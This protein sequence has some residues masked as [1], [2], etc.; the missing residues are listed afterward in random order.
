MTIFHTKANSCEQVHTISACIYK[1]CFNFYYSNYT[2]TLI[3]RANSST[4]A[5]GCCLLSWREFVFGKS[6]SSI[7]APVNQAH[8][9]FK[10]GVKIFKNRMIVSYCDASVDDTLNIEISDF[11]LW[12]ASYWLLSGMWEKLFVLLFNNQIWP[13][14]TTVCQSCEALFNLH[15]MSQLCHIFVSFCVIYNLMAV[16]TQLCFF[17]CGI[18]NKNVDNHCSKSYWGCSDVHVTGI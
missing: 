5:S 1:R 8:L 13:K 3:L 12:Y 11:Q 10:I 17:L 9:E 4:S 2:I 6:L 14:Q 7:H 18:T 15:M 16:R